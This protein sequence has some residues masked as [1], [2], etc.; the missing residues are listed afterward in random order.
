[1][2]RTPQGC[3]IDIRVDVISELKE[4]KVERRYENQHGS[5]DVSAA[6]KTLTHYTSLPTGSL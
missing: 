4:T 6:L 2:W 1:M 3:H 5:P